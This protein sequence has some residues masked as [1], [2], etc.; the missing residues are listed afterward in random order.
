MAAV[1]PELSLCHCR[2]KRTAYIVKDCFKSVPTFLFFCCFFFL[3]VVCEFRF[4]GLRYNK[5]CHTLHL[6]FK[7]VREQH[8]YLVF[9]IEIFAIWIKLFVL[10]IYI[11]YLYL[12]NHQIWHTTRSSISRVVGKHLASHL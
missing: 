4:I 7:P 11:L 8:V 5:T 6:T 9:I 2:G 12:I 3:C 10:C 1:S